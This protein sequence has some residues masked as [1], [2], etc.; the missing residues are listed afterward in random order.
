MGVSILIPNF[1]I[2]G[3]HLGDHLGIFNL[4]F[5][6]VGFKTYVRQSKTWQ[7]LRG[8]GTVSKFSLDQYQY[9]TVQTA[10]QG[11]YFGY[12]KHSPSPCTKDQWKCVLGKSKRRMHWNS[13][14]HSYYCLGGAQC[15]LILMWGTRTTK[16]TMLLV[17]KQ[18]LHKLRGIE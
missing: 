1:W 12:I 4:E 7:L 11:Y 14:Y 16:S 15:R 3:D 5:C 2:L 13:S 8:S 9:Y 10:C 17:F 18:L 6:K